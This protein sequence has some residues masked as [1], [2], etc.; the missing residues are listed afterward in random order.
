MNESFSII[1]INRNRNIQLIMNKNQWHS[2]WNSFVRSLF[3]SSRV[4]ES[5]IAIRTSNHRLYS[6][7]ILYKG[8]QRPTTN[9]QPSLTIL[10]SFCW[11]L[12]LPKKRKQLYNMNGTLEFICFLHSFDYSINVSYKKYTFTS[13]FFFYLNF[14]SFTKS[15][16]EAWFTLFLE[17]F[18][19]FL[20]HFPSIFLRVFLIECDW[21]SPSTGLS[22]HFW[23]L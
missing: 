6:I 12:Q 10:S 11:S 18:L 2:I 1:I 22:T 14:E 16:D 7:A 4:A 20:S 19:H 17:F 8:D 15:T 23:P 13:L 21:M 3:L 9:N 5:T